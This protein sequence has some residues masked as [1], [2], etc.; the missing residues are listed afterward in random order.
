MNC[1]C[2]DNQQKLWLYRGNTVACN[3]GHKFQI[4][5]VGQIGEKVLVLA[6]TTA[7]K[8]HVKGVEFPVPKGHI[9]QKNHSRT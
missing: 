3:N 1:P 7:D 8:Q 6:A 5:P 4:K 2:C 9:F